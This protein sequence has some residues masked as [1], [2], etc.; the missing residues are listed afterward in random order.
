[1]QGVPCFPLFSAQIPGVFDVLELLFLLLVYFSWT[2]YLLFCDIPNPGPIQYFS[3]WP[4]VWARLW[5]KPIVVLRTSPHFIACSLR[6]CVRCKCSWRRKIILISPLFLKKMH[7]G[8][9]SIL[10]HCSGEY[11]FGRVPFP[12]GI[13][14]LPLPLPVFPSSS[15]RR[16]FLFCYLSVSFF[17]CFLACLASLRAVLLL[18]V[19]HAHRCTFLPFILSSSCCWIS[20]LFVI[21]LFS[22]FV[23]FLACFAALVDGCPSLRISLAA[24]PVLFPPTHF[25]KVSLSQW[26][27]R[28][29]AQLHSSSLPSFLPSFLFSSIHSLIHLT[30]A[31]V[32]VFTMIL[33]YFRR[34]SF[35]WCPSSF[36]SSVFNKFKALTDRYKEQRQHLAHNGIR[37]AFSSL[38]YESSLVPHGTGSSF[39]DHRQPAKID[40]DIFLVFLNCV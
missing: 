15:Y 3:S 25:G 23:C 16:F 24:W 26:L 29:T 31:S 11:L 34:V 22:L 5:H 37:A 12:G 17:V 39:R 14:P 2:G 21:F 13:H 20:L 27:Y 9:W 4:M 1:M 38:A 36:S 32:L 30:I 7:A 33:L 35:C 40:F 19:A 10:H 28:N 8:L 6:L 18:V